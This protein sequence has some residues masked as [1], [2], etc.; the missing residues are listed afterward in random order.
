MCY[1][2]IN[3]EYGVKLS[4]EDLSRYSNRIISVLLTKKA[5]SQLQNISQ[6]LTHV[7]AETASIDM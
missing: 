2:A 4:G 3:M 5:I 6:S 7:M 1:A